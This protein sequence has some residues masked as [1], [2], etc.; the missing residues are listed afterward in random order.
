ME[1]GEERHRVMKMD[2]LDFLDYNIWLQ[3]QNSGRDSY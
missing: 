1:K 2:E 3:E